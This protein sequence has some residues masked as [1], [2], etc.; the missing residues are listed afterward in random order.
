MSD[1]EIVRGDLTAQEVDA[2]VNAAGP[3]LLG[4]GGVVGV[5]VALWFNVQRTG[6]PRVTVKW[7]QSLDGRAAAA[8]DAVWDRL[9]ER[10]TAEKIGRAHV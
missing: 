1:L 2:I 10:C 3:A 4:G 7:A 9:V 8:D 6:R 5:A